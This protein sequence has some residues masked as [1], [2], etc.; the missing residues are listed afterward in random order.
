MI[1]SSVTDLPVF[2]LEENCR[3]FHQ[4]IIGHTDS[5]GL[6]HSAVFQE[7]RFNIRSRLDFYSE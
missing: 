7:N 3:D 6:F 4:P 2:Q 1:S 5:H